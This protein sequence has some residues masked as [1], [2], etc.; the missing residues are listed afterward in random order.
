MVTQPS[1]ETIPTPGEVAARLRLGTVHVEKVPLW[2]AHWL[3]DGF[4]GPAL[5]ELAGLSGGRSTEIHDL[6]PSALADCG[7]PLPPSRIAA[8]VTV[9]HELARLQISGRAGERWIAQKVDELL[10]GEEE[11]LEELMSY[12]VGGLYC[13]TDEWSG[14][15]GRTE[16]QL[17]EVVRAACR[18]QLETVP[19]QLKSKEELT[20]LWRPTGPRELALVEASGWSAWPARL[21]DQPIFYP[22]LDRDYAMQIAQEWNVPH[23][24]T[25][26][27]TEF[28]VRTEFLD[29][30]D[31]H[32]V[33]GRTKVE[34]W[35]PAEQLDHFNDNIV[36]PIRVI[37]RFG[38]D[39]GV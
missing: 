13:L 25:G 14:G 29:R 12:P 5:A 3:V 34:Y 39:R 7:I 4:D 24:G 28:D 20:T 22:V 32:Q 38:P 8:F 17:V 15:W 16:R 11:L 33:G 21:A 36:G 37:A 18:A 19:R 9:F 27:V 26:F 2:A 35:I 6:L 10:S 30:Y 1:P 31:V 23:S